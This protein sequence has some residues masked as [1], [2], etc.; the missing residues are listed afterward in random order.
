MNHTEWLKQESARWVEEELISPQQQEALNRRYP[1]VGGTSPLLTLFS[2]LGAL[3]LGGGIVLVFATNWQLIPI[4]IKLLLAFLPLLA[5]QLFC[6][7]VFWRQWESVSFREGAAVFLS[8]SFFA[9]VALVGQ[10]FHTASSLDSYLLLCTVFL[11]PG[12]YF[13]RARA[14]MAIYTAG[15]VSIAWFWPPWV[16][17]ALTLAALPFFYLELRRPIRR[18]SAQYLLFLLS[19]LSTSAIAHGLGP[20]AQWWEIA[21]ACALLLFL[22]DTLFL[23]LWRDYF[24]TSVKFLGFLC[25]TITLLIMSFDFAGRSEMS[26]PGF[27]AVVLLGILYAGMRFLGPRRLMTGD[28]FS[29]SAPVL[30]LAAPVMGVAA[31]LLMAGLAVFFIVDGSRSLVLPK[32]NFGMGLAVLLIAIRFFDSSLSLL[33]RGL[34]FILLGC[35]CLA[36]NRWISRKRKERSA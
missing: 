34:A 10:I 24:F 31:N 36:L 15:A 7:Y 3:L 26:W 1:P 27:A 8:L 32:V 17:V 29:A 5:A 22:I 23:R 33:G 11:L 12:V 2:I 14:A 18:G 6:L 21:L 13:F 30:V 19:A 20:Y 25:S 4:P 35:A 9:A 28:L 16:A